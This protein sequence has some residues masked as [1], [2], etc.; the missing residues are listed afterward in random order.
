M[1]ASIPP[2]VVTSR[3]ALRT[4]RHDVRRRAPRAA[5]LGT[6]RALALLAGLASTA[7]A[8]EPAVPSDGARAAP[9]LEPTGVPALL[10]TVATTLE[11]EVPS[12]TVACGPDAARERDAAFSPQAMRYAFA[13]A[14]SGS[15]DGDTVAAARAWY[16][17]DAGRAIAEREAAAADM[18]E[19]DVARTL[20]DLVGSDAWPAR[21]DRIHRVLRATRTGEL[22]YALHVQTDASVVWASRCALDTATRQALASAL[23]D[24]LDDTSFYALVIGIELISP[25]AALYEPLDDATLDAYAAFAASDAGSRWFRALESASYEAFAS[26]RDALLERDARSRWSVPSTP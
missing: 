14:L 2:T 6:T 12:D 11:R 15:L 4:T 18:D 26:R 23:D 22:L 25:S 5:L 10:S 1:P 3:A 7:Q 24:A 13:E 17:S 9:P 20:E 16:D 8:G 19:R 21:R